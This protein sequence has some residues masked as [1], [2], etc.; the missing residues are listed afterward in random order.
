LPEL[1]ALNSTRLA[2][3]YNTITVFLKHH[4]IQ[5]IPTNAGLYVFAKLAGKAT[6]WEEETA[7]V[8]R[9]K[10]AGVIV[11]GGKAYHGIENE[12][13]WARLTFSVDPKQLEEALKRMERVFGLPN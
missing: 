12:K 6:T 8:Q 10:D 4:K 13:G 5:Y 7:M 1:I 3:A 9:L 11:S 2:D